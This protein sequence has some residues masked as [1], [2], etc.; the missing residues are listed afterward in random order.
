MNKQHVTNTLGGILLVL[1][2]SSAM[3]GA[4][5]E[6][7][8]M[9]EPHLVVDVNS[10]VVGKIDTIAVE[11]S[12]LV[13]KGQTL[14]ELESDVERAT[15]DLADARVKMD[16]ELRTHKTSYAFAKRKL[17]RFDELF[18]DEVVPLHKKDEV[19]TEANLA[20]LQIRQANENQRLAELEYER[21]VVLLE[22]RTVRSPITG[23]VVDRYKAPGEFAQDEPILRLAQLDPLNVEVIIPASFFGQIQTGMIANVIPE[24]PKDGNYSATVTIVDRVVDASSGT[25]GVR[26]ALPNPDYKL[27][28]GLKCSVSFQTEGAGMQT[29]SKPSSKLAAQR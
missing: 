22:Q 1:Q 24:A 17:S 9:I 29:R 20:A 2:A 3:A 19:E 25:F 13:E 4:I 5:P 23:V 26:L 27:P 10:S 11:K 16:A 12:D 18:R 14:V 28:G 7:D 21:A 15:V 6:M 8:C